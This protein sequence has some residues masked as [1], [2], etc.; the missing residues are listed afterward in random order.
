MLRATLFSFDGAKYRPSWVQRMGYDYNHVGDIRD[1]DQDGL[2][3]L[4]F[5]SSNSS[6]FSFAPQLYWG[7]EGKVASEDFNG[8]LELKKKGKKYWLEIEKRSMDADKEDVIRCFRWDG[9]KAGPVEAA[10]PR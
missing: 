9:A 2:E 3:E 6:V 7:R 1:L 5:I 8:P 10:C 4:L